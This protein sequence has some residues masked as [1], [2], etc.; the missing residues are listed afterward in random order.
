MNE[1]FAVINNIFDIAFTVIPGNFWVVC[2]PFVASVGAV[3]FI[4]GI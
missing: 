2:L 1:V 4:K 3:K